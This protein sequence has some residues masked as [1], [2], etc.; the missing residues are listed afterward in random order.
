MSDRP[1]R[2]AHPMGQ[3]R[4]IQQTA[5]NGR[6][7]N[8]PTTVRNRS[9]PKDRRQNRRH[10]IAASS[11]Y[12]PPVGPV[13]LR[14]GS[15]GHRASGLHASNFYASNF[16]EARGLALVYVWVQKR[17]EGNRQSID[18][19]AEN[20]ESQCV[21]DADGTK[22]QIQ[23]CCDHHE[24]NYGSGDRRLLSKRMRL[25]HRVSLASIEV[26]PPESWCKQMWT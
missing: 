2:R 1:M 20:L 18:Q 16:W 22:E 26:R 9:L 4:P 8:L 19:Q 17:C 12:L 3:G 23:H 11:S 21:Q 24:S 25:K 6:R 14:G 13:A 15:G 7:T 10:R 5:L